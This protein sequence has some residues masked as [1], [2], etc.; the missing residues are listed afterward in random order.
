MYVKMQSVELL[1]SLSS[2]LKY[3]VV[4]SGTCCTYRPAQISHKSQVFLCAK[5]INYFNYPESISMT[6]AVTSFSPKTSWINSCAVHDGFL[7]NKVAQEQLCLQG[8]GSLILCQ[9]YIPAKCCTN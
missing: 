2:V 5:L 1:Q 4:T 7:E 9:G 6:Q 3:N 8:Q